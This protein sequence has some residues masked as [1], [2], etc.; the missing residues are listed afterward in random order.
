MTLL[1]GQEANTLDAVKALRSWYDA[2][3][4]HDAAVPDSLAAALSTFMRPLEPEN[5]EDRARGRGA[6][7]TV[8]PLYAEVFRNL[9][10]AARGDL[11]RQYAE[12]LAQAYGNAMK[13]GNSGR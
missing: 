3:H 1:K 8:W 11:P 7:E 12:A 5:I 2:C 6:P 13:P 9:T 4:R 10:Q